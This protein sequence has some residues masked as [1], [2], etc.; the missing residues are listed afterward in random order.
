MTP[1]A[2]AAKLPPPPRTPSLGAAIEGFAPYQPQFIC[3]HTVE[4]GVAAFEKLVLATYPNT[5]SLG[6]MRSCAVGGVSEHEDGRAWDWGADHR[7]PAQ[8]A[9]GESL[10]HWLFATD[11]DG[12]RDAMFRRLGLMYVIWNK[13]MWG[14]WDQ[15]WEP[16]ACSGVTDCHV[17]HIHFSFGWA[18]ALEKTS[19]WTGTVAGVMEPPLPKLAAGAT[20]VINLAASAG[21]ATA[22]WLLAAGASYR[23]TAS[24]VWHADG[25]AQDAWCERTAQGWRPRRD[26][27][28]VGG[29]QVHEWGQT[30]QALH[31][32]GAGC[33]ATTHRYRLDL[34]TSSPSTITVSLG[35]AGAASDGGA[36]KVRIHRVS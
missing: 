11:A 10:L 20:R 18:G 17:N 3:R 30:W 33:D 22:H 13:R 35:G 25:V 34:Q 24:G 9:A 6:D 19:F 29:D 2:A 21:D 28:S 27:I 26:G 1:A 14:S 4:P 5:T 31:D 16:Y 36:V 7:V 32:N 15:R 12:N 23:I 8:R